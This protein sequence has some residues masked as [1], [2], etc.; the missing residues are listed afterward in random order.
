LLAEV[1]PQAKDMLAAPTPILVLPTAQEQ[2]AA[3]LALLVEILRL[4]IAAG[5]L[6]ME[7]LVLIHLL[8]EHQ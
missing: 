2:G 3:V 8:Q 7:G 1:E 6:A 4:V 5:T